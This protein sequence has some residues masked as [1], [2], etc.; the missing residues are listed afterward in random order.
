MMARQKALLCSAIEYPHQMRKS[1]EKCSPLY[2][3]T[4]AN[5]EIGPITLFSRVGPHDGVR[6]V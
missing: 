4:L 5:A 1:I 6:D 2:S 3:L